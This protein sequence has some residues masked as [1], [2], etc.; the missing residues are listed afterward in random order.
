[1]SIHCL[2]YYISSQKFRYEKDDI[3]T[4]QDKLKLYHNPSANSFTIEFLENDGVYILKIKTKN[5]WH[6][7][8]LIMY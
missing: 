1:M 7:R 5:Q 6:T 8:K 2:P 4:L 3:H